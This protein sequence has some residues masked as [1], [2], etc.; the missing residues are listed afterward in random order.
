MEK[1]SQE[2]S[3]PEEVALAS[4]DAAVRS[5]SKGSLADQPVAY[6]KLLSAAAG[7]SMLRSQM[8]AM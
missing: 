6:Y 1:P 3:M 4:L 7:E 5:R 8:S 2:M